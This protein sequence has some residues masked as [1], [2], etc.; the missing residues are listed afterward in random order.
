MTEFV[1][2]ARKALVAGLVTLAYG[3]QAAATD[4][5]STDEWRAIIGGAIAAVLVYFVPN[6]PAA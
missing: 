3:V 6:K 1:K 4:G 5:I 2:K